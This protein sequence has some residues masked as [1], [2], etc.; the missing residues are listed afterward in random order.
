MSKSYYAA[1]ASL[2]NNNNLNNIATTTIHNN[3]N[4]TTIHNN[5]KPAPS[6]NNRTPYRTV[7]HQRDH[8]RSHQRTHQRT[9]QRSHKREFN[10]KSKELSDLT[11]L[12]D[13]VSEAIYWTPTDTSKKDIFYLNRKIKYGDKPDI[14]DGNFQRYLDF[15]KFC[16][17]K[18][19]VFKKSTKVIESYHVANLLPED[20]VEFDKI[21][22]G[23]SDKIGDRIQLTDLELLDI[24]SELIDS[25]TA[26]K[27]FDTMSEE[28][29]KELLQKRVDGLLECSRYPGKTDE[30]KAY[31]EGEHRRESTFLRNRKSIAELSDLINWSPS[32]YFAN[33]SKL[34]ITQLYDK[35]SN[36]RDK[37]KKLATFLPLYLFDYTLEPTP[38]LRGLKK[39]QF[40]KFMVDVGK[41]KKNCQQFKLGFSTDLIKDFF[42]K[43]QYYQLYLILTF[44]DDMKKSCHELCDYSILLNLLFIYM[45]SI[46]KTKVFPIMFNLS[47]EPKIS[48]NETSDSYYFRTNAPH[49]ANILFDE[50]REFLGIHLIKYKKDGKDKIHLIFT[51]K[52]NEYEKS[53]TVYEEAYSYYSGKELKYFNTGFFLER[54]ETD[55]FYRNLGITHQE[56]YD[57]FKYYKLTPY[58]MDNTT[59]ELFATRRK[60]GD[61]D[62]ETIIKLLNMKPVKI[63]KE[64]LKKNEPAR[65]R[66][67]P[68]EE[69]ETI[70]YEKGSFIDLNIHEKMTSS[71]S[72]ARSVLMQ[73]GSKIRSIKKYKSKKQK[74]KYNKK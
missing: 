24:N 66:I 40:I 12:Q 26:N 72:R 30:E 41:D 38:I 1:L 51:F 21:A 57:L 46:S 15:L 39:T 19:T 62:L 50:H 6:L 31:Y 18:I 4:T 14:E 53:S 8:Q 73:A 17:E 69:G 3:T 32:E 27:Y 7:T 33:F 10:T 20:K 60:V 74:N 45:M 11:V 54:I 65:I 68:Y 9:H 29:I 37:I 43:N 34:K 16:E 67:I 63:K 49:P 56:F 48:Y 22:T 71:R 44:I 35:I 23:Y 59:N 36:D 13:R 58:I 70:D 55:E 2:N 64:L 25:K 5:T 28:K 47:K 52:N 61:E 42:Y